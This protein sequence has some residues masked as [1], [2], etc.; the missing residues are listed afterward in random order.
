MITIIFANRKNLNELL[1]K[2]EREPFIPK[3][4]YENKL[5][6]KWIKFTKMQVSNL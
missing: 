6:E 4:S 1:I 5:I 2:L 3:S